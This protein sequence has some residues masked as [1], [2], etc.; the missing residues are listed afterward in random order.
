MT[1]REVLLAAA[2]YL[3]A[4]GV[5]SPRVDAEL[6]LAQAL[7]LSRISLYTEHDR[8][9][10]DP[11][12][13]AAR[14]LVVRRG[15]REPL[16]Y[17]LG[18][19]GFRRLVL[20]TD[21]RALVPRPETEILVDRCL[22]LLEGVAAPR[23]ADVGTGS[24]AIALAIAHERPDAV[25][26][27][28]DAS[29]AALSLARENAERLALEVAF[30]HGDLLGDLRGPFDLVASNPPY[31]LPA[32]LDELEPELRVEPPEALVHGAAEALARVA[33]DVLDGWIVLEVH[34]DRANRVSAL[35]QELEYRE[36]RITP[37]LAGRDRVVEAR[38]LRTRSSGR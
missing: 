20:R 14:E 4:R 2:D 22:G 29:S 1:I 18:E 23:V 38:W 21:A 26:S 12:R 16:A 15:R 33:R 5:E 7:G 17:V 28:T 9:L 10:T 11:E 34:E 6:I 13:A 32:E 24:G 3:G 30:V 31:V 27:A 19:W 8:P 25:V 37:D 36:V 35:L